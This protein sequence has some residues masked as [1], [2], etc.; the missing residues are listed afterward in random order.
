MRLAECINVLLIMQEYFYEDM[1]KEEHR[2]FKM[3]I[4]I[5]IKLDQESLELD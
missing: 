2:A 3:A 5:L 1:T 4:E